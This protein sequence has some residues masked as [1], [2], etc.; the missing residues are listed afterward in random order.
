MAVTAFSWL[1]HARAIRISS[2]TTA[3]SW[4]KS[5]ERPAATTVDSATSQSRLSITATG[6]ISGSVSV[7]RASASNWPIARVVSLRRPSQIPIR[8][9]SVHQASAK[10]IVVVSPAAAATVTAA[11]AVASAAIS[12][13]VDLRKSV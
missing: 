8:A 6:R 2:A 13:T 1:R 7:E 9:A 12:I 4:G 10:M 11:S 3:E 5:H